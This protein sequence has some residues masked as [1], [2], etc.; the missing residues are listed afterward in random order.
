MALIVGL[1]LIFRSCRNKKWN[2][3]AAGILALLLAV[4]MF[5]SGWSRWPKQTAEHFISAVSQGSHDEAKELLSEPRQWTVTDDGSVIIIAENSGSVTL[6]P[7]ELPLMAGSKKEAVS[8]RT[9]GE[10]LAAKREF[11]ITT[12]KN[13][14]CIV[15]CTAEKG[16]VRI[17]DVVSTQYVE[18][19]PSC[20][21]E[22]RHTSRGPSRVRTDTIKPKPSGQTHRPKS[23]SQLGLCFQERER[24]F[25]PPTSSLGKHR[26]KPAFCAHNR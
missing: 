10:V 20:L 4:G 9:L 26:R 24:G 17:R 8:V 7:D 6:A 18:I 21:I 1:F 25:E 11:T 22:R 16:K 2:W 13:R 3:A 14:T 12:G 5:G 15:H 19:V 23:F